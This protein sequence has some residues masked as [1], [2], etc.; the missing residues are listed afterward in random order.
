MQATE[1]IAAASLSVPP[2]VAGA[3]GGAADA[4]AAADCVAMD[5]ATTALH[6]RHRPLFAWNSAQI[7]IK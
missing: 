7:L 5:T 3:P 1:R 4:A 2:A 6:N